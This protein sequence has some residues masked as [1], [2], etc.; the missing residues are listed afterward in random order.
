M[1]E[2]IYLISLRTIL[3]S[4]ESRCKIVFSG[5]FFPLLDPRKSVEQ[6]IAEPLQIYKYGTKLEIKKKVF[7]LLSKVGL[8][9][10]QRHL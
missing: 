9:A 6:V 8:Y 5:S 4:T 2:Q 10:K 3:K 7:E 1:K